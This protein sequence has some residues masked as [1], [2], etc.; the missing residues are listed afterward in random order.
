MTSDPAPAP[1]LPAGEAADLGALWAQLLEAVG[2]ASRFT[3]SYLIEAHPISF[4]KETLTIGFDPEFADHLSLVDNPKNHTLIQAKLREMG[5]G[6]PAVKFVKA[7]RPSAA[8]TAPISSP[9][10]PAAK[11]AATAAPKKQAT[12][13]MDMD[14]FKKDPLIQQALEEFKGR[15]VSFQK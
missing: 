9:N 8:A 3:R 13:P 5:H 2:R 12:G 1:S 6:H 14:A 11:P 4:T 10:T 15:V 7:E